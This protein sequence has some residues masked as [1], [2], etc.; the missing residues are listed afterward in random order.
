[1]AIFQALDKQSKDGRIVA[2][3][4]IKLGSRFVARVIPRYFYFK[5]L[6]VFLYLGQRLRMVSIALP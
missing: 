2:V 1:M 4:K 5:Y 6:H 3:K